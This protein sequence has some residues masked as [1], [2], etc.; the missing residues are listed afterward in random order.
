MSAGLRV[1]VVTIFPEM[2]EA[3][4]ATGMLRKAR[5]TGLADLRAVDLRQFAEGVHRVTDDAAF[6]GEGGQVMKVE[7]MV[8][9]AEAL[10]RP[11]SR[12]I[13]LSPQGDRFDQK[14]AWE[15]VGLPHLILLCGR[16]EGVDERV[17]QLVV[18]EELSVG[19]YVLSGGELAALVVVDAVVRL[20]PGVLHRPGAARDDSFASGLLEGPQYT[21]P[22]VFRGLAVPEVLLSGDHAAVRRWRRKEALR[23]TLQRRPDLL[24]QAELGPGD[25]QL[26]AEVLREE[27][28]M[29]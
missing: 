15:Y 9:A 13:L 23:R 28:R 5:E 3:V 10:R 29:L 21:R 12:V 14:R 8:R 16:Y 20:L 19:D 6:G 22:R 24:A 26:L 7:P 25:R 27:G 11:G 18:D 17:R 1:D 2:V 4:L